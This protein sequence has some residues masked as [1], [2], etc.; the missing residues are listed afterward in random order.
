[1]TVM[2]KIHGPTRKNGGVQFCGMHV[3]LHQGAYRVAK[4]HS[5]NAGVP[6][7][8]KCY[9]SCS[10]LTGYVQ[11]LSTTT[12]GYPKAQLPSKEVK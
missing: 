1:M 2:D 5:R 12:G 10:E 11:E 6:E 4:A 8:K 7:A 3:D 9:P